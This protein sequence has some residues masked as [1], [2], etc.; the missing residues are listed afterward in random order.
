L[1]LLGFSGAWPLYEPLFRD[2]GTLKTG[3]WPGST[4][5]SYSKLNYS[6]FLRDLFRSD[7][8]DRKPLL[9]GVGMHRF[10]C[11]SVSKGANLTNKILH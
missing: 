1:T 6:N 5:D 9:A 3:R 7:V 2:W 8:V 4:G 10:D 11:I